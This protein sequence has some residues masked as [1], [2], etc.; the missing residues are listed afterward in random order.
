MK[1]ANQIEGGNLHDRFMLLIAIEMS[2]PYSPVAV[3]GAINL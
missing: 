2:L 3:G 1:T